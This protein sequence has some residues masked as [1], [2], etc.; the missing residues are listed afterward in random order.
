MLK[1]TVVFVCFASLAKVLVTNIS[2]DNCANIVLF[3]FQYYW[4]TRQ[5]QGN[6]DMYFDVSFYSKLEKKEKEKEGLVL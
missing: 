5:W 1:S 3:F 6:N 2:S 4:V